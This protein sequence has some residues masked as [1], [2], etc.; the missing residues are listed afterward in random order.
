MNRGKEKDK[1]YS[2][3]HS[4]I[5]KAAFSQFT[6]KGYQLATTKAIAA[7]AGINELTLFRHFGSKR[8]LFIALIQQLS[9]F[10]NNDFSEFSKITGN[11]KIDLQKIGEQFLIEMIKIRKVI[12]MATSETVADAQIAS[13]IDKQPLTQFRLLAKYFSDQIRKGVLRS[14]IDA[15]FAAQ[16]FFAL[17]I[18]HS[19]YLLATGQKAPSKQEL[20]SIVAKYV[21]LF[22]SGVGKQK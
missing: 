9:E 20:K 13:K 4:A 2:Q 15:Q 21:D 1:S 12:I 18:E 16:A 5:L 10:T 11:L 6:D 22:I 14:D 19:I 7:K 3:T 8:E 17:F